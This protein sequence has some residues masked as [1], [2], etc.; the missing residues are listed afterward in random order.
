LISRRIENAII[1]LVIMLLFSTMLTPAHNQMQNNK[2]DISKENLR[3][4]KK[5]LN[6]HFSFDSQANK[7]I[8]SP[9]IINCEAWDI[10]VPDD[11]PTIQ[12]AVDNAVNGFRIFV[13]TGVY[14]ENII[15]NKSIMLK[16]ENNQTTIIDGMGISDVMTVNGERISIDGF[17][18]CNATASSI[19]DDFRAGIRITCSNNII[20]NN[21]IHTNNAGV[22][23]RRAANITIINNRFYDNGIILSPYDINESH[24]PLKKAYFDHVIKNCTVND[25]PLL[26]L[27]HQKDLEI[28]SEIGQLVVFN[29]SNITLQ[30]MVFS[31][32]NLGFLSFYT[33]YCRISNSTFCNNAGIW[34]LES[35]Y[36]CFIGNTMKNN[37]HG[38]T[39]DYYSEYN[40]IKYNNFI[41]NRLM[42]IMLEEESNVNLI[43]HNNFINNMN[44]N[45]FIQNSY[46]NIWRE[47][48]WDDWIG[49]T[50]SLF[51]E[52]PK[53]ILGCWFEKVSIIS[54]VNFDWKPVREPFDS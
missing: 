28:V 4:V 31:K 52:V 14:F 46:R 40:I 53:V 43:E 23:V 7:S 48:Y 6:E 16:G 37:F 10:V 51:Q 41:K 39:L 8:Q 13:R 35:D 25:E 17:T 24:V 18:V 34:L 9:T 22:F 49:L 21:I 27:K 32:C 44:Q 12:E 30:D 42:G 50:I 5:Y 29:C 3:D 20:R 33:N 1:V 19:Y 47:N 2:H 54:L 15:I 45:A 11:Y 36:N 26:Y 38:I